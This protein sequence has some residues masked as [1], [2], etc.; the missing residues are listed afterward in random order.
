MSAPPDLPPVD[1]GPWRIVG[2]GPVAL[3]CALFLVRRGVPASAIA[4]DPAPVADAPV[5]PWLGVRTLAIAHGTRQLLDRI[6][7]MPPAGTI[8]CVEVSLRGHAGRTRIVAGDLGVPAL[9][10]VVRYG[11]L[12]D[13]LRRAALAHRW[14]DPRAATAVL[15]IHAEG[16]PGDEAEVRDFGQSALLGEVLAPRAAP[17]LHATAFER[18]TPEGP[19]ALLPLPEPGRWTMVWCDEAARCEARREADPAALSA[20]LGERFGSALGPLQ[21]AGP[22]AVAPL[23]RRSRRSV[24]TDREVWIGN[25]A[26]A[27]H[28]VAGQGLNLGVRDAF[29]LADALA[30]VRVRGLRLTDALERWRRGRRGDRSITIGLTDLMAASFTWPLARP[31]QSPLLALLDALP[32]L[33]RP[34]AAQLMFGRR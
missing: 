4:L 27:L 6:A 2:A 28:P 8:T 16:D 19:L 10:H 3:A 34:L 17:A 18:F 20:E 1:D 30:P 13:A 29:E 14:A 31:L 25:A 7:P 26:Q 21:V 9:G 11:P 12:L 22:L 24:V 23:V 33:R 32:P 5:P 15:T